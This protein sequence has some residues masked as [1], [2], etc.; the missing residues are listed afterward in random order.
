MI[1]SAIGQP[2]FL[3]EL[4][5]VNAKIITT[6]INSE[7]NNLFIDNYLIRYYFAKLND[8]F[9]LVIKKQGI[10]QTF[11]KSNRKLLDK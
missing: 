3:V 4:Q 7:I 1:P 2:L 9:K 11:V 5:D 8:V 10:F 6:T